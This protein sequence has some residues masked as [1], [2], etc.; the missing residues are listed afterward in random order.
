AGP[1]PYRR[2]ALPARRAGRH[3]ERHGVDGGHGC[4]GGVSGRYGE[5]QGGNGL[6]PAARARRRPGLS[7]RP[8]PLRARGGRGRGSLGRARGR[9]PGEDADS[10]PR[11]RGGRPVRRQR[12]RAQAA[13]AAR[14][15]DEAFSRRRGDGQAGGEDG[16]LG[17]PGPAPGAG[18]LRSRGRL[19]GARGAAAPRGDRGPQA[20]GR[21]RLPPG[22]A[23]AWGAR[24][25]RL[26]RDGGPQPGNDRRVPEV[27]RRVRGGA[28][29][30]QRARRRRDRQR[31]RDGRD[32]LRRLGGGDAAGE[33][34]REDTGR[35][36][37]P[38]PR[39]RRWVSGG[40]PGHDLRPRAP[41]HERG[42]DGGRGEGTRPR[43]AD[44]RRSSRRSRHT[45]GL[46]AQARRGR[47]GET[48][49]LRLDGARGG[50]GQARASS[51]GAVRVR[52]RGFF[53]Q[54]LRQEAA[55]R[56]PRPDAARRGVPDGDK[57]RRRGRGDPARRGGGEARPLL[58]QRPRRRGARRGVAR[59][60][61]P[62]GGP[63]M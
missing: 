49:R 16:G 50:A 15:L 22:G 61:A 8:G 42:A 51:G 60:R 45:H 25:E 9:L 29:R 37:A 34:R 56:G 5:A 26:L 41:D 27:R 10:L 1:L 3:G 59:A 35:G 46:Q 2:R 19:D 38:G 39:V 32:A 52:G 28:V 4:C 44:T 40:L 63:G 43:Q 7:G 54:P 62:G 14:R 55:G 24:G 23:G 13:G 53:R 30:L 21:Q 47:R 11:A 17:L 36:R 48:G 20:R 6:R 33:G 12:L 18:G 58:R 31:S 57:G